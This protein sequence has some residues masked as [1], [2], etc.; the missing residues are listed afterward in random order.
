VDLSPLSGWRPGWRKS[1][2]KALNYHKIKE[3]SEGTVDRRHIVA[4]EVIFKDLRSKIEQ[5]T[6]KDA[7]KT[8][9]GLGYKPNKDKNS[10]ILEAAKRYLRDK[11]NDHENIWVGDS[12]D[13]QK[14]G[15]IIAQKLRELEQLQ[16]HLKEVQHE[17]RSLP[18]ALK[19]EKIKEGASITNQIKQVTDELR[20]ARL[21]LPL[22]GTVKA[23]KA[24]YIS[25]LEEQRKRDL[26]G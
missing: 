14:R 15:R 17:S 2:N 6:Y 18:K 13:N 25:M 9:D 19:A 1:T 8:L 22:Q 16:S 11:F 12:E 23:A 3:E 5:R 7:S 20:D 24:I 21:D 4:F 10:E 26:V